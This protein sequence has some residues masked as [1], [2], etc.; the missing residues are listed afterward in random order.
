MFDYAR[1]VSGPH[2]SS[3]IREAAFIEA[4][5]RGRWT[6][7]PLGLAMVAEVIYSV[8]RP[9]AAAP[10]V[11]ARTLDDLALEVMDQY[12]VPKPLSAEHWQAAR[13][14]LAERIE[15][16]TLAPPKRAMRIPEPFAEE[17]L[18]AMPM[19]ERFRGR[20]LVLITNNL[21]ANL[22]RMH[23]ELSARADLAALTD[24]LGLSAAADSASPR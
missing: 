1:G 24:D 16:I 9:A 3:M 6:N 13:A 10:L 7:Y 21:R 17:F 8:L 12:A 4:S 5:D 20:D 11:L 18:E 19:H 15:K 23:D 22:I 2:F 14:A